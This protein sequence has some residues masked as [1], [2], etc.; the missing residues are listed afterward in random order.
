MDLSLHQELKT[1]RMK[2]ATLCYII[3]GDKILLG[4]KKRGLGK[5][6][7]NGIGG[8]LDSGETIEECAIREVKEEIDVSVSNLEK[9]AEI[10]FYFFHKKEFNQ[11]V[12]VYL[13]RTFKGIPLETDEMAPE[14]FPL[15]NI[16]YDKMWDDDQYWLPL[17]LAGKK[18]KAKVKLAE[19]DVH[20][21]KYMIEFIAN[22]LKQV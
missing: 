2:Q 19:D 3:D 16:P 8:K 7:Y 10:N 11:T 4:Y 22:F 17:L 6:Y 5:G 14:W 18:I 15:D 21:T 12:F 20:I 9:V 13:C 1:T